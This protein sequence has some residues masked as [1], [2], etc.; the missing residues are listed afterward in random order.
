MDD[1]L[2]D[3]IDRLNL[4]N[5][6]LIPVSFGLAVYSGLRMLAEQYDRVAK[7]LGPLGRRWTAA[8]Q[9][10]IAKAANV[11]EL[12]DKVD[13]LTETIDIQAREIA[14]YRMR[15]DN[16]WTEDLQTQNREL[17]AIVRR[18]R[19]RQELDDAYNLY[20]TGWHRLADLSWEA[21]ADRETIIRD[22][23]PHTSRLEFERQWHARRAGETGGPPAS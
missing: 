11:A 13:K 5:S 6:L 17:R 19:D 10:R 15:D 21:A 1:Q 22:V 16:A 8:R 4:P 9:Q 20:D 23:P 7:V 14:W 2:P 12:T 18:L 3:I